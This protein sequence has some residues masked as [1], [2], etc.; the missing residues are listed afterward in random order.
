MRRIFAI[1]FFKNDIFLRNRCSLPGRLVVLG[2][3]HVF[4]AN[5]VL[6]SIASV[7]F[8]LNAE[9]YTM[10]QAFLPQTLSGLSPL[11]EF[12]S[13]VFGAQVTLLS[14][15]F[16]PVTVFIGIL[17]QGKSSNEPMWVIYR[18]NSGFMLVG[19]SALTLFLFRL[20]KNI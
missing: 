17:L 19:H 5:V 13:T 8:F 11:V 20:I 12:Q 3:K 1:R 16:P 18:H 2:S 14:L 6:F 4:I 7:C 10:I 9:Y 15:I